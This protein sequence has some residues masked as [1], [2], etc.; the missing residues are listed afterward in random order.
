VRE[1][2]KSKEEVQVKDEKMQAK[3]F[4]IKGKYRRGLY[5]GTEARKAEFSLS[6][7]QNEDV[8]GATYVAIE[9]RI[10]ARARGSYINVH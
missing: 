7:G 1:A 2:I 10:M 5:E 4:E 3:I 8:E 6:G 9:R